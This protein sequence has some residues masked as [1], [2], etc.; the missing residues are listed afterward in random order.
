MEKVDARKESVRLRLRGVDAEAAAAQLGLTEE[1]VSHFFREY[2]VNNYSP[3]GEVEI[4]LTQLARLEAMV[5]MLWSTV[6]AGDSFTEGKQTANMLKVIEEINKLMGAYRD[7]LRD[8]QVQLTKA[9]TEQVYMVMSELRGRLM[10]QVLS[11]VRGV[12]DTEELSG[13]IT[14][15]LG[16][17]VESSWSEW[18]T[19]AYDVSIRTVKEIEEGRNDRI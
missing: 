18:F 7:P 10:E 2:L 15:Q 6:E 17:K 19:Q 16:I 9:Q 3:V 8:A 1:E 4:R 12:A 11:G 14:E 5:N 13:E